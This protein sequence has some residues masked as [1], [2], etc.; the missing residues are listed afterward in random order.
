MR[1]PQRIR[2]FAICII[3][4]Q[5]SGTLWEAES[6]GKRIVY[7]VEEIPRSHTTQAVT[8]SITGRLLSDIQWELPSK[9]IRRFEKLQLFQK[10]VLL[11]LQP[12]VVWMLKNLILYWEIR[13]DSLM[14]S[15]EQQDWVHHSQRLLFV[16][17]ALEETIEAWLSQVFLWE[18]MSLSRAVQA[19]RDHLPGPEWAQLLLILTS[20]LVS[21]TEC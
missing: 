2:R 15:Q 11:K 4:C 14:A 9:K 10:E 8:W 20:T 3:I 16:M 12:S 18:L 5:C 7:V 13:G 17:R 21:S 1:N 19:L 6:E